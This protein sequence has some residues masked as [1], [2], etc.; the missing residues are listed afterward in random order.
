MENKHYWRDGTPDVAVYLL[1]AV[2]R[3]GFPWG[4]RVTRETVDLNRNFIVFS[5]ALPRNP[6]YEALADR[7][8]PS[9]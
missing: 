5:Q 1:H 3:H 7:I 2:N 6:Y 8:N 4:W 9:A